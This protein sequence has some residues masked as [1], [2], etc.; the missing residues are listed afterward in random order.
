[1]EGLVCWFSRYP[2]GKNRRSVTDRRVGSKVEPPDAIVAER[3]G[4][5][6]V[7]ARVP[8]PGVGD[9]FSTF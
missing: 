5:F 6:L 2:Q 8:F 1:M 9:V 3:P 4:L 7:H